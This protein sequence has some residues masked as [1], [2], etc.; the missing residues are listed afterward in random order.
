MA[1][2]S[3]RLRLVAAVLL[4]LALAACAAP[5][6]PPAPIVQG[7]P[8]SVSSAAP[9]SGSAGQSAPLAAARPSAGRGR[10]APIADRRIDLNGQCK[11]A[12]EDGF[13][14]EASLLVRDNEVR[15]LAWQLWVG[16]KGSCRFDHADFQQTRS[17]PH[18]ELMARDGSG[19]KLM[20]WQDPRRITLAH[21]GC[22]KRCSGGIY[23]QAWPVMFDPASGACARTDR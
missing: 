20:V 12:E 19:C 23:E 21:A 8:G 2:S 4:G 11:Q 22:Q 9:Y 15:S 14:E 1:A 10:P 13:R 7:T 5:G 6:R 18:I 17:A 16:R 3:Q